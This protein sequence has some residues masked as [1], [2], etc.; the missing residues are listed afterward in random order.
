MT[1]STSIDRNAVLLRESVN[2]EPGVTR[3][4]RHNLL[5]RG[6]GKGVHLLEAD[7]NTA[8][9]IGTSRDWR[10]ATTL[11]GKRTFRQARDEDSRRHIQGL[12]RLEDALRLD[13]TLLVGP[14]CV[15][16]AAVRRLGPGLDLIVAENE[17]QR[18]ALQV[19]SATI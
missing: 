12:F 19:V 2:V 16:E 6:D 17:L 10:V 1:Y 15:Y 5:I 3:L 9:D 11:G 4:E 14:K 18:T 7:S 13:L 8:I